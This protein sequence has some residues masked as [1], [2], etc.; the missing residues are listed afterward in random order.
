MR[1]FSR[2]FPL[3]LLIW[4]SIAPS[5]AAAGAQAPPAAPETAEGEATQPAPVDDT[6]LGEIDTLLV[7]LRELGYAVRRDG[8]ILTA[9]HASKLD[10]RAKGR[11]GGLVLVASLPLDPE[12]GANPGDLLLFLNQF[13]ISA[14]LARAYVY[15]N[16]SVVFE[17]WFPLGLSKEK[18]L[19]IFRQWDLDTSD[20]LRTHAET[21]RRFVR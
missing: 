19:E 4:L 11:R 12:P 21:L 20:L 1:H 13:N 16:Q 15:G 10:F 18:F 7:V 2:I 9:E 14:T 17:T 8:E 3:L 5:F 6:P